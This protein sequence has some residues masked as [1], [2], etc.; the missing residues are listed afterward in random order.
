[1]ECVNPPMCYWQPSYK[2][3]TASLSLNLNLVPLGLVRFV[4]VRICQ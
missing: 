2:G 4:T 1:M 3:I